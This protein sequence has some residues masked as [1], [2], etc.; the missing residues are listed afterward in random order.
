MKSNKLTI[1]HVVKYKSKST[2]TCSTCFGH[3][4]IIRGLHRSL[5]TKC[6]GYGKIDS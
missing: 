2:M 4:R 5:C 3:G 1:N 6:D